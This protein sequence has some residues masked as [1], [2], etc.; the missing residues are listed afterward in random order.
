M[1]H[2]SLNEAEDI[3]ASGTPQQVFSAAAAAAEP[4]LHV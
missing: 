2:T 3:N 4:I 1:S